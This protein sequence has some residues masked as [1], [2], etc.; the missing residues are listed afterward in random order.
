M[1]P[2][3]ID[4]RRQRSRGRQV[5][6]SALTAAA[7]AVYASLWLPLLTAVAWYAGVRTA[8]S[9]IYLKQHE[10]DAFLLLWVPAIAL[11][12]GVLLIGWAEYNRI[13]FS[14]KDRRQRRSE[15]HADTV[16]AGLGVSAALAARMR[17]GRITRVALDQDANPTGVDTAG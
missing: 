15:V 13:R 8:Y 2:P 11:G 14:K 12:C 1:T 6:S 9:H 16:S 3:I 7:W 4:H 10:V 5:A 17:S